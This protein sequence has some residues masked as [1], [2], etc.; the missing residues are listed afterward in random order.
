MNTEARPKDVPFWFAFRYLPI[1]RI[2]NTCS[3]YPLSMHKRY[4]THH[5]F[6]TKVKRS[7]K[8]DMVTPDFPFHTK[9]W[10]ESDL[11][12]KTK[13]INSKGLNQLSILA[14]PTFDGIVVDT[15][16]LL[17]SYHLRIQE[18]YL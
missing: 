10:N 16:S 13:I 5:D 18:V 15:S 4:Q 3:I 14:T 11:N 8:E 1:D 12:L 7:R 6:S 17:L 9:M 2:Y